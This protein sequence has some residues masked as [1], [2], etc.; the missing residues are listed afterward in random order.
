MGMTEREILIGSCNSLE[1]AFL[2]DK[3]ISEREEFKGK[4]FVVTGAAS[5]I[6]RS[7][8]RELY[9]LGANVIAIDVNKEGLNKSTMELQ[10]EFDL[11]K[12]PKSSKEME[13]LRQRG[14]IAKKNQIIPVCVDIT[15]TASLKDFVLNFSRIDGAALCAGVVEKPLYQDN[16]DS[17]PTFKEMEEALLKGGEIWEE[18]HRD[19]QR[20]FEIN[21]HA[22]K[23]LALLC[24]IKMRSRGEIDPDKQIRR[25]SIVFVGSTNAETLKSGRVLA[26][27]ASKTGLITVSDEFA[28]EY[29]KYG[30]RSNIVL[31]GAT[32]SDMVCDPDSA[33]LRMPLGINQPEDVAGAIIWL[34]SNKARQ[35]T[36]QRLAVD[37]GRLIS[38]RN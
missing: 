27:N 37:G 7:V 8:M 5:G 13:W 1:G 16:K 19:Q 11:D 30:I 32:I 34:L 22:Q 21:L 31:P 38:S 26:Y 3:E 25:G 4:T 28:K 17:Q 35:I 2:F 18:F 36:G 10:R 6:G 23:S 12:F 24:A 20:V 14:Y 9:Y 33:S 29:A 15:D